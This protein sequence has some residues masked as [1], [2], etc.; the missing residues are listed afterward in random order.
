M[1]H[2]EGVVT[3]ALLEKRSLQFKKKEKKLRAALFLSKSFLL[4]MEWQGS[5]VRCTVEIGASTERA[6]MM[7]LKFSR[8]L[9]P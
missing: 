5:S 1:G 9:A 7:K 4:R 3:E 8:T 2:G 6:G